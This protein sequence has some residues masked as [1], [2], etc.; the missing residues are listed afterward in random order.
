MIEIGGLGARICVIGS[1]VFDTDRGAVAY[2]TAELLARSFPVEF[3]PAE[4]A[5]DP[6][7]L[8]NGRVLPAADASP[9]AAFFCDDVAD[10]RVWPLLPSCAM[11]FIWM[12]EAP[13]T[14]LVIERLNERADLILT[15]SAALSKAARWAG[16]TKPITILPIPL[17]LDAPLTSGLPGRRSELSVAIVDS[18]GQEAGRLAAALRFAGERSTELSLL[19]DGEP[20]DGADLVVSFAPVSLAARRSL[21]AGQM[22]ITADPDLAGIPGVFL[23][24]DAADAETIAG[25]LEAA[26]NHPAAATATTRRL[27]AA[28]RWSF[29]SLAGRFGA[30][31]DPA[32]AHYRATPDPNAGIVEARLGRRGD[33]IGGTRRLVCPAYDAGFFSIFNAYISHLVWQEREDRCHGVLPD[34]D[35]DRLIARMD[36]G[37]IIGNA[38]SFCYGQP[39]DGNLWLKLFQPVLGA[40]EAEMQSADFLWRHAEAPLDRHNE[41]REPHLTYT[42][43][44]TLYRSPDFEAVRRQYHRVFVRHV[45]LRTELQAEIDAFAARVLDVPVRIAAHV[46]HPSHTVEQPNQRIAHTD[47]YIMRVQAELRRQGID[48]AGSDWVVFV[49]TDQQAVLDRFAAAFGARAVFYPDARRTRADEDAAFNALSPVEQNRE[50]HQLQHL[51]AADRAGWSWRM[52]WE[53]VRDAY[54][55]ARCQ[56]LLHVVSNVSTAVSYMN[57]GLEMIFCE[58]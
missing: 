35:V 15:P 57:P 46:R 14:E 8:P 7:R 18:T 38:R 44:Y 40:N 56:S 9:V 13:G 16:V 50:G 51:V 30:L 49:A 48:P 32:I 54:T 58:A 6:I 52:A 25:A 37:D 45:R 43:A 20:I 5:G 29:A 28:Q 26:R 31:I 17:D 34:W 2:A 42:R 24:A 19:A 10:D 21:A 23:L 11:T 36:Q 33:A 41:A 55:M 1:M 47:A 4:L 22:V 12:T 3:R 53:V 27:A 39:G